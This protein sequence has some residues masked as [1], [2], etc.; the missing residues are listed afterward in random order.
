MKRCEPGYTLP[1]PACGERS[2]RGD[3]MKSLLSCA[4]LTRASITLRKK[5]DCRVK[6]GNDENKETRPCTNMKRREFITLLGGAAATSS[7]WP[8]GAHAQQPKMPVI[9]LLNS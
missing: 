7:L 9:G 6:P 8:L 5:M 4:G 1:L 3:R 2:P